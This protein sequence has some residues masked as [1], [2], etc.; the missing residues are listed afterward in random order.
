MKKYMIIFV[1]I[2]TANY[3][4]S[5][6]L[7]EYVFIKNQ[8][9]Q[10]G[11]EDGKIGWQ[12][13][14]AGRPSGPSALAISDQEILY[15]PDRVNYRINAYDLNLN[16]IKTIIEKGNKECHFAIELKIDKNE[17]IIALLS[18][19]GLKK[20]DQQG[21]SSF[22][23]SWHNL[24]NNGSNYNNFFPLNGDIFLYN[25]EN[26]IQFIRNDGAIQKTDKAI[27]QLRGISIEK[28]KSMRS[29]QSFVLP[30]EIEQSLEKL[31]RDPSNLI[32]DDE[33]YSADF[34]QT[35]SYFE[36]IKELRNFI[37]AQKEK[38]QKESGKKINIE[39]DS[40]SLHFIGYDKEHNSYWDASN[41]ASPTRMDYSI[42]IFSKY[43][44]LL[45]AF[46]YGQSVKDAKG[47]WFSSFEKYPTTNAEIAVAPNGDVYFLTGNKK[48]YTFYKVERK[49]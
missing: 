11:K 36:K 46:Y 40:Y 5:D 34:F 39:L 14:I 42:I 8:T 9:I 16:L 24:P 27:E 44:E 19:K 2:L 49:W 26:K 18:G 13:A 3:L 6:N 12:P 25:N 37:K 47:N 43:G 1:F 28:K 15:V 33:F 17:N 23:I 10:T 31:G 45:D 29:M 4:N 21:Y 41:D 20:I 30:S 32:V 35:K 38:M 22:F 48:E 7:N